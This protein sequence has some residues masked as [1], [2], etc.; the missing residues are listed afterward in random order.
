MLQKYLSD[1][2]NHALFSPNIPIKLVKLISQDNYFLPVDHPNHIWI[3]HLNHINWDI[4]TALDM[5]RM[6]NDV[7]EIIGDYT[8]YTK[9]TTEIFQHLSHRQPQELNILILEGFLIYNHPAIAELCQLKFHLHIPYEICFARRSVRTYE[10]ADVPGYFESCIW[11]MYQQYFK[12]FIDQENVIKLNGEI[13][14]D[15]CFNY[16]LNC[17]KNIL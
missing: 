13:A 3:K 15:K 5:N 11:P 10:P 4:I 12:D 7:K 16:I 14:T 9:D 6:C 2:E 1:P 17:I 8:L